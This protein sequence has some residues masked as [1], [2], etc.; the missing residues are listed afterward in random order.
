MSIRQQAQGLCATII[1]VSIYCLSFSKQLVIAIQ[2]II[3]A[4]E[5]YIHCNGVVGPEGGKI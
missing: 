1:I 3:L 4:N 5:F 2:L